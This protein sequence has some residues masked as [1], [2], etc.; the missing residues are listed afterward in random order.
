MVYHGTVEFHLDLENEEKTFIP[1][2]YVE[3]R[4]LN[5]IYTNINFPRNTLNFTICTIGKYVKDRIFNRMH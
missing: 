4:K 2:M 5:I 3:S 1:Y